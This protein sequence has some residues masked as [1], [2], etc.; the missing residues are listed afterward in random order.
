M[1]SEEATV[2]GMKNAVR[3]SSSGWH[4]K[5][6]QKKQQWVAILSASKEWIRTK[7]KSHSKSHNKVQ[8]KA[9]DEKRA[10]LI[11]LCLLFWQCTTG[12]GTAIITTSQSP[13]LCKRNQLACRD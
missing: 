6:S 4:E 3:R 2:G 9:G 8:N 1:Q 11:D 12:Q 10:V 7:N 5:C 13:R